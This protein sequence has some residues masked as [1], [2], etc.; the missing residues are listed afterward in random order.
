MLR[1]VGKPRLEAAK[2]ICAETCPPTVGKTLINSC[3]FRD[4]G[5]RWYLRTS[6]QHKAHIF[7][8]MLTEQF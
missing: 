5:V 1:V 3:Y 2:R 4:M 8:L 6:R 7:A